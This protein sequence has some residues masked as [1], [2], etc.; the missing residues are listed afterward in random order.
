MRWAAAYLIIAALINR[1]YYKLIG[2][3][4]FYCLY[5][6][7]PWLFTLVAPGYRATAEPP[8]EVTNASKAKEKEDLNSNKEVLSPLLDKNG[9]RQ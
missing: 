5:R 3:I 8:L 7:D 9:N 6:R 1:T 4:P 2:Y